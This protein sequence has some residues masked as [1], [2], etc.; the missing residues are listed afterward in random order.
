MLVCLE[1]LV[2]QVG[3]DKKNL[4]I[5]RVKWHASFIC[6]IAIP[7]QGFQELIFLN[8]VCLKYNIMLAL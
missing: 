4:N 6:V 7:R 5:A 2:C 8:C 3:P 1:F